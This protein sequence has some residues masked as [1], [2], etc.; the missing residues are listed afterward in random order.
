[1]HTFL[2]T[3]DVLNTLCLVF[4]AHRIL[5]MEK[6]SAENQLRKL[7]DLY[8]ETTVILKGNEDEGQHF[9]VG[10][11]DVDTIISPVHGDKRSNRQ[12][13]KC[14]I[15][16]KMVDASSDE[17][18]AVDDN[19]S[20]GV[21][22]IEKISNLKQTQ[23]YI[24][25]DLL[26]IRTQVIKV[27]LVEEGEVA[28]SS[29]D[30]LEERN[31]SCIPTKKSSRVIKRLQDKEEIA[32][33]ASKQRIAKTKQTFNHTNKI[34]KSI[35]P[36]IQLNTRRSK[37]NRSVTKRGKKSNVL[38]RKKSTTRSST[39]VRNQTRS[40]LNDEENSNND[41]KSNVV[42]SKNSKAKS[43]TKGQVQSRT[44]IKNKDGSETEL[45][46]FSCYACVKSFEFLSALKAHEI[47][48]TGEK[49]HECNR[50]LMRFGQKQ[51]L[52]RHLLTHNQKL[53]KFK[54]ESCGKKFLQKFYLD[55]HLRVH[56]GDKPYSCK[57]CDKSFTQRSHLNTHVKSHQ[58]REFKCD[59]CSLYFVLNHHL[60]T[61]MKLVH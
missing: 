19:K 46:R 45:L 36:K 24:D 25:D 48:H 14:K 8:K 2:L 41:K 20:K 49:P 28:A 5:L 56:S 53:K 61:H 42:P 57:E 58:E 55:V 60:S 38:T 11:S 17:E 54:C 4:Q 33:K 1:M 39:R 10:G 50:C 51:H 32:V 23:S 6:I 9:L 3:N 21:D 35:T 12:G 37:V 59:I 31:K 18:E 26:E 34:N 16:F 30:L 15:T 22:S 40:S 47:V 52:K 29:A 7:L 44:H 27:D 13:K 43:S